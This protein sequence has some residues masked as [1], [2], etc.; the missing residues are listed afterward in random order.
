MIYLCV[1]VSDS[2]KSDE[3]KLL[4]RADLIIALID[5]QHR[6]NVSLPAYIIHAY[7][8]TYMHTCAYTIPQPQYTHKYVQEL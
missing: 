5:H 2:G 1:D 3:V 7:I 8:P 4:P 6:A